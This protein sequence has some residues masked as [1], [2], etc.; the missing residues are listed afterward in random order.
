MRA[1]SMR[2]TPKRTALRFPQADS[3]RPAG[4]L[5]VDS[6][7]GANNRLSGLVRRSGEAHARIEIAVI[8][9]SEAGADT[10]IS[11]RSASP[12]IEGL[13]HPVLLVEEL[14]DRVAQAGVQGETR[15]PLKLVLGVADDIVFAQV[16]DWQGARQARLS[17][18]AIC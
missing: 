14:E 1:N 7:S 18:L 11:L 10:A 6:E 8:V 3:D 12:E 4:H 15:P 2:L 16:V 9:F 13:G 17:D 5:V